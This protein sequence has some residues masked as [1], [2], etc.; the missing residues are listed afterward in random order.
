MAG[1]ETLPSQGLSAEQYRR[2]A[3]GFAEQHGLR[4]AWVVAPDMETLFVAVEQ[5]RADV[6]VSNIAVTPGRKAR[7]AFS[8]P[9]TRSQEWVIGRAEAGTFGVAAGTSYVQSLGIHY[10]D[11]QRVPVPADADPMDFQALLEEG[12]INATIMDEAA[13]RVVVRTSPPFG[14]CARCRKYTSTHGPCALATP[15]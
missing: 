14:S 9:L 11:A 1:V 13:A 12:V 7:L 10:P 6:A 3:E 4:A 2:L 15:N 8:L 5:G